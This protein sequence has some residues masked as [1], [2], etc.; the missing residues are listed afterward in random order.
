MNLNII[1]YFKV[2]LK[3]FSEFVFKTIILCIPATPGSVQSAA[4]NHFNRTKQ[5]QSL[6]NLRGQNSRE[7]TDSQDDLDQAG[8]YNVNSHPRYD[9]QSN[10]YQ[11]INTNQQ[12]ASN[13]TPTNAPKS[14][15]K[16]LI[17]R[18]PK[19]SANFSLRSNESNTPSGIYQS[20]NP[21]NRQNS[22]YNQQQQQQSSNNNSVRGPNQQAN[23][24]PNSFEQLDEYYTVSPGSR[25]KAGK[26]FKVKNSSEIL[27]IFCG[28]ILQNRK[29]SKGGSWLKV[30]N[31]KKPL[32]NNMNQEW[33]LKF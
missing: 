18:I 12:P 6:S 11:Q 27:Q 5:H 14:G 1:K 28:K 9:P 2:L 15:L 31:D 29:N 33:A 32:A 3:L 23:V 13:N 26:L 4:F 21:K 30:I 19:D 24:V 16:S 7:I 10:Q 25:L 8:D 17:D 22:S 20:V